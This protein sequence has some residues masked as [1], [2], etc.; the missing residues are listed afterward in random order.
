MTPF[1]LLM[2]TALSL[3]S[4]GSLVSNVFSQPVYKTQIVVKT[5]STVGGY[6][7]LQDLGQGPSLNDAG[8]V[9][10]IGRNSPSIPYG[11]VLVDNAGQIERNFE[12][13]SL[14]VIEEDTQINNLDQVTWRDQVTTNNDTFIRRLDTNDGG[15]VIGIGSNFFTTPFNFLLLWPSINNNGRVV[16]GGDLKAGGTALGARANGSDPVDVSPSLVGFPN[17]VPMIADNNRVVVKWGAAANAP[18]YVF[19]NTAMNSAIQIANPASFSSFGFRPGLSDDGKMAGYAGVHNTFF[20]P[21]I[22]CVVCC[23]SSGRVCCGSTGQH[24]NHIYGGSI[25]AEVC[26][27]FVV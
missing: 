10:F 5:G 6:G 22:G 26:A 19:V 20:I 3:L 23:G 15:P 11:R 4:A 17:F 21:H 9:S 24:S 8:K 25:G 18:L 14:Q 12:I 1:K 7:P 2:I 27:C 16:F 13:T